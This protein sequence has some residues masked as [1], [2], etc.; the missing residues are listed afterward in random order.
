MWTAM[1][2]TVVYV[3]MLAVM[4]IMMLA[5]WIRLWWAWSLLTPTMMAIALTMWSA[6]YS[7]LSTPSTIMGS[8]NVYHYKT[9]ITTQTE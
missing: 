1:R 7:E 4:L 8:T 2:L 6:R 5:M 3:M 9:I